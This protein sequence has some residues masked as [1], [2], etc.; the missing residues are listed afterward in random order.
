MTDPSVAKAVFDGIARRGRVERMT[1]Q[2]LERYA[3]PKYPHLFAK[4][5]MFSLAGDL[6]GKRVLEIGCGQGV[7]AVQMAHCG[8]EVTGMDISP[9]SI[10]V[11]KRRAEIQNLPA[12]FLVNDVTREG[13]P[14]DETFDIVWCDLVLHHLV[15]HLDSVMDQIT[16]HLSVDGMFVAREPVAYAGW[17]KRFRMALPIV[18]HDTPDGQ[19]LRAQ[20]LDLIRRHF[21]GLHRRYYRITA[22]ADSITGNM[23]L[24]RQLARFDNV[25]LR[26]PASSAVAGNVV[27]WGHRS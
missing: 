26:V 11:A 13:I 16:S 10:E 24:L 17:L 20:D 21:P 27:L 22:R 4:E 8:A 12:R 15:G 9:V 3:T 7:A 25:L 14:F 1:T 19:P 6:R 5:M 23:T 2:D 18:S